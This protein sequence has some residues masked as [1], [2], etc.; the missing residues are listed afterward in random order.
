MGAIDAVKLN[1]REAPNLFTSGTDYITKEVA[2]S[3]Y[4]FI[5]Y[6]RLDL[7]YV[8][9]LAQTLRQRGFSV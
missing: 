6:A 9:Q 8:L 2:M 4:V 1:S 7:D 3:D 5:S